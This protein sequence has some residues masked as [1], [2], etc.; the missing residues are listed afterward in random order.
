MA[1]SSG[2]NLL[3]RAAQTERRASD[4]KRSHALVQQL[5]RHVNAVRLADIPRLLGLLALLYSAPL[6]IPQTRPE[7]QL[8]GMIVCF[9]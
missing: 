1:V 4:H 7:N 2:R 3:S 6:T 5:H 9:F 8:P